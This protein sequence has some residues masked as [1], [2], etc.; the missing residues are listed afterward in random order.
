MQFEPPVPACVQAGTGGSTSRDETQVAVAAGV[1]T[2]L[3]AAATGS[4]RFSPMVL[5][6]MMS[7]WSIL[8]TLVGHLAM[9][10]PQDVHLE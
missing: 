4:G 7:Y 5:P 3:A 8:K 9:Q 10:T 2:A 1:G 6:V